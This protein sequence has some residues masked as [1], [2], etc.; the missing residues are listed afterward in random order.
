[1]V[2]NI[3][4][5]ENGYQPLMPVFSMSEARE[6]VLASELNSSDL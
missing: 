6:L 1:M 5:G 2:R 4:H 3:K